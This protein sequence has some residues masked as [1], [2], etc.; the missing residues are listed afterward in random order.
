MTRE[1]V[2]NIGKSVAGPI[3]ANYVYWILSDAAAN[4]I[5]VIY[6]LA[7]DGYVLKKIAD[8][9]CEK[10]DFE[11][12]CR[13]LYCSRLALRVPVFH[14]AGDEAYDLLCLEGAHVTPRTIINGMNFLPKISADLLSELTDS[15][16]QQLNPDG[17]MAFEE[18]LKS[19]VKFRDAADKHSKEQ[20]ALITKY[21]HQ[22]GLFDQSCVAI[23]DSGWN[24]TMQRS[25]RKLLISGGYSGNICGY[26]FGLYS[27]P[28]G[29]SR[30]EYKSWYF[31]PDSCAADKIYFCN[32]VIECMLSAPHGMTMGYEYKDGI[33]IPVLKQSDIRLVEFV[34]K[35]TEGV[36]SCAISQ[37]LD[38]RCT[39]T[40]RKFIHNIMTSPSVEVAECYGSLPF[41]DSMSEDKL[42]NLVDKTQKNILNN[43]LLATRIVNK[44]RN[45]EKK[46]TLMW[47]YGNLAFLDAPSRL[48]YKLNIY[49]WEWLKN[50]IHQ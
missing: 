33:V 45:T 35:H 5:S 22:E 49:A 10:Y 14:L 7:R 42:T 34:E 37:T 6:F 4:G 50:M 36:I 24:G 46:T 30:D 27:I 2:S 13:Y 32:N 40:M 31:D 18:K 11:I 8:Q 29:E 43:Y 23:A 41:C 1:K 38:G 25:M 17:I 39:D 16:D 48:W 47:P 19:S 9:L 44:L 28:S 15:P 12:E 21:F 3:I 26:Y 20:Y